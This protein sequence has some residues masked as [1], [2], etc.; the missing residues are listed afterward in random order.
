MITE[1]LVFRAAATALLLGPAVAL[2]A[3][4]VE[5]PSTP[6][7]QLLARFEHMSEPVLETAFLQCDREARARV[8]SL[9]EGARCAM[10]WDALL[11]R[12]FAGNVDALIAWWKVKREESTSD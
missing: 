4:D 6:R 8:L 5:S 1:F 12:V 3:H 2:G 9:D 11:R 7:E 10:A